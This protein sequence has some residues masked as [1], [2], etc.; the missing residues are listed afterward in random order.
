MDTLLGFNQDNPRNQLMT[1]QQSILLMAYTRFPHP[2][3]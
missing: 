1:T 3:H 2:I